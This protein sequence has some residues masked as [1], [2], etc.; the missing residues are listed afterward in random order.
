MLFKDKSDLEGTSDISFEVTVI[1]P[2]ETVE[3]V[4][5]YDKN[6]LFT[7]NYACD[8]ACKSVSQKK[9]ARSSG[10]IPI[11]FAAGFLVCGVLC[12]VFIKI[13]FTPTKSTQSDSSNSVS[14]DAFSELTDEEKAKIELE[15]ASLK[16]S[17]GQYRG[18]LA[19]C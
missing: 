15:Q 3:I 13:A 7:V 6:G 10:L 14:A 12:T 4:S 1:A 11:V 19:I 16:F 5:G 8:T 9:K 18:G 17:S 2:L